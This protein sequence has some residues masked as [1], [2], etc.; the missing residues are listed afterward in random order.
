MPDLSGASSIGG[1]V[2]P[3][4]LDIAALQSDTAKA[5]GILDDLG[6]GFGVGGGGSR[7]TPIKFAAAPMIESLEKLVALLQPVAEKE[8]EKIGKKLAEGIN[9]GQATHAGG[10]GNL[11]RKN[12][13]SARGLEGLGIGGSATAAFAI[14]EA[15]KVAGEVAQAKT[16]TAD[17]LLD[18]MS[19]VGSAYSPDGATKLVAE[20]MAASQ[21]SEKY[22]G[23]AES[24]PILGN[25]VRIGTAGY[26]AE[27]EDVQMHAQKGMQADQQ[28]YQTGVQHEIEMMEFRGDHAEATAR[29]REESVKEAQSRVEAKEKSYQD[30]LV[31]Q[32]RFDIRKQGIG[33]F[34]GMTKEQEAEMRDRFMG[35]AESQR[36]AIEEDNRKQN[37]RDLAIQ[38]STRRGVSVSGQLADIRTGGIGV[39]GMDQIYAKQQAEMVAFAQKTDEMRAQLT[40][41]SPERLAEFEESRVKE[42]AEIEKR[43]SEEVKQKVLADQTA[44]A[45]SIVAGD[46]AMLQADRHYYEAKVEGAERGYQREIESLQRAHAEK[47]VID[48]KYEEQAQKRRAVRIEHEYEVGQE[49][50]TSQVN[51]QASRLSMERQTYEAHVVKR[52]EQQ[53]QALAK[54][55]QSKDPLDVDR[56]RQM[57][58][59][60]AAQN[61]QEE[62]GH[63][64][65]QQEKI[66]RIHASTEASIYDRMDEPTAASA[67]Q[68]R[69]SAR[70]AV[71]AAEPGIV[72]EATRTEQR[73]RIE[74]ERHRI[75]DP[76]SGG[77][78]AIETSYFLPGDPIG[79]LQREK[80][81][82]A[83]AKELQGAEGDISGAGG[84]SKDIPGNVA[85]LVQL[86]KDLILKATGFVQN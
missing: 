59:E 51:I 62:R 5:R 31:S 37:E 40:G 1:V 8:G 36:D 22:V 19:Q 47:S 39:G 42:H 11:A 50:A 81:R 79:A 33:F 29:K 65:E 48:A 28:I 63:Q 76:H 17:R 44:I 27:Q 13:L 16:I 53:R 38:A 72:R 25:L 69:E 61:L 2:V 68:L 73:A 20:Q 23:I 84:Q 85:T 15:M 54:L 10:H 34:A 35:P 30:Y 12:L 21:R 86:M 56:R 26:H 64:F 52:D 70:A 66:H 46:I 43:Q 74:A 49:I 57:S 58:E 78:A 4:R 55:D 14:I 24:I 80:D 3:L 75:F 41:K 7:E 82:Q 60:F 83:A 45:D 71:E 6:K 67:R 18:K 9:K 32:K 77:A